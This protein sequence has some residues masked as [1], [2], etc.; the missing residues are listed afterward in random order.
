MSNLTNMV[1]TI[2]KLKFLTDVVSN[3]MVRQQFINVYNAV[4]K[5][6]GEQVYEREANYFNKILRENANL[7]G[8]TSLSVFFAFIDLAVQGISVEPGV[9]AMAY[10]LPRNYKIGT[11]QQ[12]KSVYEK[13][14]N[15]T[16]SGYGEL[17][18]RARAGQIYH[19][20]NPVV[21]YEG[22]D[23]EYG[24]R[25]GRKYVNYSMHI[26]RTSSHIIACFLKITRTDG[27]I[28]YSVM[29]E[30]DWTRLADYSAKNNKY[31]DSSTRQWV[32]KANELYTS[33]GGGIDPAFLCSKCIKHAF[34]TYPKLNIGK[35][36]QLETT[37]NDMPSSDF[38]PYGGIDSDS[39]AGCNQQTQAPN[40]S[41]APPADTSNGV[42]ID[43]AAN[44]QQSQG[45]TA[46]EAA[47]D[48]F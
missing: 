31:W 7:N 35:G 32:E 8:C 6:G 30:Q 29:L 3:D 24:E 45:G 46:N 10:L 47:D 18:L 33:G 41:F 48:T 22:D 27:T 16:I 39:A 44:T 25:D 37:V 5:Q 34:G 43:P 9:R 15:L 11:D 2:N 19:A 21:V 38:D 40:D 13:R 23:F 14:C 20:D 36:T 1:E 28:D 42:R 4:W 12:G 26:P 17:Y